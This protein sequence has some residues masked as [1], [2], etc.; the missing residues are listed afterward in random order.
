MLTRWNDIDRMLA[1]M[2][3][4]RPG[5]LD[6]LFSDLEIPYGFASERAALAGAPRTNL[7]DRGDHFELCAEVPGLGKEN[8][9]VKIQGNYLE[10]KGTRK[11]DVPAGYS[12]HRSERGA[13]NFSRSLTLPSEVDANQVEATLKNGILTLIMPKAE[14]AKPKQVKIN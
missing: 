11:A 2:D 3:M 8:L 14:A 12:V 1:A 5:R 9:D 13:V 4:W 6:R 10:I 7:Y